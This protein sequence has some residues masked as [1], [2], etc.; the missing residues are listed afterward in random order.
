MPENH[1]PDD[2]GFRIVHH[3]SLPGEAWHIELAVP[4]HD[5]DCG[6]TI[7]VAEIPGEDPERK[8]AFHICS[9][10]EYTVPYEVMVRLTAEA[11]H[12]AERTRL[13]FERGEHLS[14]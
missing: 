4:P 2:G 13:R 5:G 10:N 12:Q 11:A 6:R 8:S 1:A 3:Y 9:P 14:G 7:L